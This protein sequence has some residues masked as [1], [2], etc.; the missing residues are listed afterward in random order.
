LAN[1]PNNLLAN[2]LAGLPLLQSPP[3]RVPLPQT[4]PPQTRG[5]L[6]PDGII[7]ALPGIEISDSG[8]VQSGSRVT[9]VLYLQKQ[10]DPLGIT[11]NDVTTVRLAKTSDSAHRLV[12]DDLG[13]VS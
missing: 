3:T 2:P 12:F 1:D 11:V 8:S 7:G 4:D 5:L 6:N 10:L 9:T 13:P